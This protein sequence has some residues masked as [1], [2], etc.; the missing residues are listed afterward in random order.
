MKNKYSKTI[1]NLI[2]QA[3]IQYSKK[4]F[5]IAC[6]KYA[7]ACELFNKEFGDDDGDLLLLYGKAL[8]QC[9]VKN[10]EIFSSE[11]NGKESKDITDAAGNEKEKEGKDPN[12]GLFQF[13]ED[14]AE[15]N[16]EDEQQDQ[17]NEGKD[18]SDFEL[19]WDVL[20][21]AR[22]SFEH[23]IDL[24]NSTHPE[25]EEDNIIKKCKGKGKEKEIEAEGKKEYK[26]QTSELMEL[27]KRLA[28]SYDLLGEISLESENFSQAA[29]DLESSLKL[30]LEIYSTESTFISEAYF[31]LSLA[32]EFCLD[33]PT[34]K[35]KS[36]QNL[37]LA[38]SSVNSR[39]KKSG[40]DENDKDILNDLQIRLNDL[41]K[42]STNNDILEQQKAFILEGILGN[43]ANESAKA[44]I[45]AAAS[46]N[47]NS[48][49]D[50]N[51]LVKKRKSDKTK[52]I[53]NSAKKQKKNS[54]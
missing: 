15:D 39:I 44:V 50:I 14:P 18:E 42:S 29:V 54:K 13:T 9:G 10:S 37:E 47:G 2:S 38:I 1:S 21:L 5:E 45:S 25:D 11:Q 33:D 16:E 31:K 24:Y 17:D 8:F 53:N 49:H 46:S 3:N 36:I 4:K 28:E 6:D 26:N 43:S 41:K 20:E 32:L 19:A 7:E 27:K 22:K 40:K 35:S 52:T 12:N 51:S 48:V 23:Q 34:A 30:K